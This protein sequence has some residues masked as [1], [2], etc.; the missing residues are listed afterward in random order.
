VTLHQV[1]AS[2]FALAAAFLYATSNVVEQRTASEAPPEASM[3]IALLWHL[4]HRPSLWL[5]NFSEVGGFAAQAVALAFGSLQRGGDHVDDAVDVVADLGLPL[6]VDPRQGQLLADPRRV[7]VDDLSQQQF[8]P[9]RH[10]LA[11]HAGRKLPGAGTQGARS[12]PRRDRL[13]P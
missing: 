11:V 9:D 2:S 3:R 10:D 6:R 13:S 1:L 5:G 7:R 4:A 12:V 8:G